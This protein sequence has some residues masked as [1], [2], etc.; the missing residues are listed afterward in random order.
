MREQRKDDQ[1]NA[2]GIAGE[3]R[4]AELRQD[5]D[6]TDI[7]G[8]TNQNLDRSRAGKPQHGFHDRQIEREIS[9]GDA[10]AAAPADERH[11]LIEDSGA[12]SDVRGHRGAGN[13]QRRKGPE[14]EDETR[15][16][17]DV[18]QVA[19][20]QHAHGDR[21]IAGSTK[22]RVQQKQQ[23]D[24]GVAAEHG[25]GEAATGLNDFR[26]P[27]HQSEQRRRV[28]RA[29]QG[30]DGCHDRAEHDGLAGHTS[31]A[32]GIAFPHAPRDKRRRANREPHGDGVDHGEHR[33]SQTDGRNRVGTEVRHPEH[34]HDGEDRFHRH[35]HHHRHGEHDD[36]PADGSGRVINRGTADRLAKHG[37]HARRHG[38]C[39][40][41]VTPLFVEKHGHHSRRRSLVLGRPK[42]CARHDGTQQA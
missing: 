30:N 37:P 33:L 20:P 8:R 42:A 29:D 18:Q 32:R 7:T 19:Q 28:R 21:R 9:T 36:G 23:H 1:T 17:G 25:S 15:P 31:G 13:A 34:V 3:R 2:D 40:R 35:L 6:E 11:Q 26:R 16:E 41:T 22:D 5:P 39:R 24:G 38:A 12:A 27:S 4:A 14:A 10:D